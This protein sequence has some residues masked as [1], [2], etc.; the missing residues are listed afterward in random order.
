M[1]NKLK[2]SDISSILETIDDEI[3]LAEIPSDIE[4]VIDEV[5][6]SGEEI[7]IQDIFNYIIEEGDVNVCVDEGNSPEG[8][9]FRNIR[10][11]FDSDDEVPLASLH[12]AREQGS[13][14]VF[15][16]PQ[17]SEQNSMGPIKLFSGTKQG[18]TTIIES[19]PSH[20]NFSIFTA[21]VTPE[22]IDHIVFQTNL[23]A[24]QS[25][26]TYIPTNSSEIRVFIG[27]NFL[28]GLKH[29]GSY[30]DYWSSRPEL[31]DSYISNLMP[32]KRFDWLL[33][34]IHLNDSSVMPKKGSPT[35]D[36]L[37]KVQ[38]FIGMLQERFKICYD[39]G[40]Y[41]AVDESMIRFKGKFFINV[42]L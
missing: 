3:D 17:W 29:Q 42:R 18:P 6:I 32:V 16:P 2:D 26:K 7:V 10:E 31:N 5:E 28:M 9:E 1:S 36:K 38:P 19:M 35:F 25:G 39:A 14:E 30:R 23:Y 40:E 12:G 27:I 8:N 20:D 34:N 13:S 41:L 4:S 22:I 24:Q 15:V 11:N 37:Y 21:I 33:G